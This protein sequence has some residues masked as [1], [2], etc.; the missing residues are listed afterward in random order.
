M[1]IPALFFTPGCNRE[2][3][4][5]SRRDLGFEMRDAHAIHIRH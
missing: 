1:L 5:F 3:G 2:A 4:A